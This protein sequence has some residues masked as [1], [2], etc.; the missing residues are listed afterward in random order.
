MADGGWASRAL[1]PSVSPSR[2]F[3]ARKVQLYTYPKGT[4]S[5]ASEKFR[6]IQSACIVRVLAEIKYRDQEPYWGV[7]RSGLGSLWIWVT[8]G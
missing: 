5:A 2:E 7:F 6:V 1:W 4:E 8:C 3:Y